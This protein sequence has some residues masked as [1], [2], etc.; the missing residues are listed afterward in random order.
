MPRLEA[1][2]I[3]FENQISPA[4]SFWIWPETMYVET[5]CQTPNENRRFGMVGWE[6][7]GKNVRR[8]V[9]VV[10][11]THDA[12]IRRWDPKQNEIR[13]LGLCYYVL[14]IRLLGAN[15][16]SLLRPSS[17]PCN[18]R[19]ITRCA[20]A[21]FACIHEKFYEIITSALLHS[22]YL[23]IFMFFFRSYFSF[24]AGYSYS[25]TKSLFAKE[26]RKNELWCSS[27]HMRLIK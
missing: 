3:I 16:I 24:I 4:I 15:N 6:G 27:L 19:S 1:H 2:W 25:S 11:S 12:D 18:L 10:D 20:H 22:K 7:V 9:V 14:I 21:T 5:R 23:N 26:Q 17:S 13:N 8:I